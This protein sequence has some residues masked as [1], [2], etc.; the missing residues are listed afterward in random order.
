MNLQTGATY[1]VQVILL[2]NLLPDLSIDAQFDEERIAFRVWLSFFQSVLEL[3]HSPPRG[4]CL[5]VY[6]ILE[7]SRQALDLFNLLAQV[8]PQAG[9]LNDDFFLYLFSL[10]AF[11]N[12]FLVVIAENRDGLADSLMSHEPWGCGNVAHDVGQRIQ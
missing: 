10:V 4:L 12:G 7:I 5:L 6:I 2:L 1:G 8:A 11:R 9:K 3:R